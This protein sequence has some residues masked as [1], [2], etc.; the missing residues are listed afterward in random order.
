MRK[1]IKT[2]NNGN[3]TFKVIGNKVSLGG[4]WELCCIGNARAA[5]FWD[6]DVSDRASTRPLQ[7]SSGFGA[8]QLRGMAKMKWCY[9]FGIGG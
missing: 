6:L 8:T 5:F 3:Y 2:V 4:G 9:M 7:A 1:K